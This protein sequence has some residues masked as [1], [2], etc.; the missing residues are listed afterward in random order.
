MKIKI[1]LIASL[2]VGR[3]ET[4]TRSYPHSESVK[5]VIE[6]LDLPEKSIGVILINGKH[7]SLDDLLEEGDTLLFLPLMDGG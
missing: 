2:S 5:Q 7:A 6:D 1:D 3:F 4:A